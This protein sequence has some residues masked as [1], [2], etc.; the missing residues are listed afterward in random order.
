MNNY[1]QNWVLFNINVRSNYVTDKKY[2]KTILANVELELTISGVS[3]KERR[4]KK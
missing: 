3:K 1:L 2:F 4:K